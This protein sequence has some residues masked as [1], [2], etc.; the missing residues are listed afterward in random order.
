M[1]R[2]RIGK[3]VNIRWV[4][5]APAFVTF[6]KD[7][8][9]IELKDPK[10]R[11][12][13]CGYYFDSVS[14]EGYVVMSSLK[15]IDFSILGNYT[16]SAWLNK[17]KPG[18]SVVDMVNAF[19][20][21]NSTIAED[22]R[23]DCGCGHFNIDTV[24]IQS[25]FFFAGPKGEDGVSPVVDM[26]DNGNSTVITITDKT[27]GHQFVVKNGEKGDKGDRGLR[28]EKGDKGDPGEKGARGLQGDKGD[29]FTYNDFTPEQLAS[30]KGAKGDKGDKGDKGED[31]DF[32]L[33]AT[34][35]DAN[36]H[37]IIHSTSDVLDFDIVNK[38]L[39]IRV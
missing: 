29:P 6:T 5:K 31:G 26:Y 28:G 1:R 4:L 21:V 38:H 36:G 39:V 14:D 13:Q 18:Q 10:G 20:L 22:N 27:G 9:T 2:I 12:S 34:E 16:L 15:G 35:I 33:V 32:G 24:D 23:N 8:L 25:E 30:L 37:L 17:D 7:N 11:S 3:D 19:S